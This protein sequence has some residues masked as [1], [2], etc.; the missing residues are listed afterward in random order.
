M[1]EQCTIKIFL[2]S[3]PLVFSVILGAISAKPVL[4]MEL[5]PD[6]LE[7][8]SHSVGLCWNRSTLGQTAET[9]F[10]CSEEQKLPNSEQLLLTQMINQAEPYS[11]LANALMITQLNGSTPYNRNPFTKLSA[12]ADWF[13]SPSSSS[14]TSA[15]TSE[16]SNGLIAPSDSKSTYFSAAKE[17]G[18]PL[19]SVIGISFS[20]LGLRYVL[21]LL[22]ND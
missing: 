9:N 17:R 19:F 14:Y 16:S 3:V 2:S 22:V 13:A 20:V 10:A 7:P 8:S 6:S 11:L 4:A 21:K 15:Q 1:K 5:M 18:F 12:I